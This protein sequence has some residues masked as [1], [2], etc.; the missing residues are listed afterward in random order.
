[1]H[2]HIT[3]SPI[4]ITLPDIGDEATAVLRFILLAIKHVVDI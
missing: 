1:M 3:E 4:A 2:R